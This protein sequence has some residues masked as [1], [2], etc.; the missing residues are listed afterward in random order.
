MNFE[1]LHRSGT[2]GLVNAHDAG[3]AAIAQDAG[4]DAREAVS[5]SEALRRAEH[6]CADVD[7]DFCVLNRHF[8][9]LPDLS[10]DTFEGAVWFW[11][12]HRHGCRKRGR[13]V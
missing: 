6:I 9:Q 7:G 8:A 5:R 13:G 11:A 12:D 10:F 4:A 1:Q 3:A 2:F